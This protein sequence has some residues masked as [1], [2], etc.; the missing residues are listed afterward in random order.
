MTRVSVVIPVKDDDRE[1]R[2]CLRAL[3][4]QT[5][6]PDEVIV[7]DNGSSD[8]SA[9]VAG[10]AGARVVRCERAGIPAAS[11]RGYDAAVGDVILRLDADC[12]PALTW[13]ETMARAFAHR[14]DVTAFTGGARFIDGPRML[15]T[16]LALVYLW[17]YAIVAVPSLGHLPLYG[18]NMGFRRDAWHR[19]RGSVHLSPEVHDDLDLAYHLGLRHR[20]RYAPRAA[21]GVSMRPFADSRA[22]ARR[23]GRGVRSVVVHWPRDFPPVRWV[24]LVMRRAW[25]RRGS[26]ARR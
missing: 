7:V 25:D 4:E 26:R 14:P 8:A 9:D 23:A 19:I 3:A 12:V 21:M 2:R 5:R 15:R 24:H 13:V 17:A 6:A 16:P 20:I 22:F 1:L 10:D 18:S 11:A